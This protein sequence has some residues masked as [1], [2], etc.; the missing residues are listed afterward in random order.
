[1]MAMQDLTQIKDEDV[2]T[3]ASVTHT[4]NDTYKAVGYQYSEDKVGELI[5]KIQKDG[6]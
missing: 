5:R 2:R 6:K 3:F 4:Q 1:M